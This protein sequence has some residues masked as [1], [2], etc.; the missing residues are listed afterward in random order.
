MTDPLARRA[1][2]G[3]QLGPDTL[4]FPGRGMC[5]VG[6]EPDS[7]AAE[8]E[9]LAG[10]VI[11]SLA[12]QS[13]SSLC[14]LGVALRCAGKQAQT[15]LVVERDGRPMTRDV[16]VQL[17]P[18]EHMAGSELLYGEVAARGARLRSILSVPSEQP[19]CAAVLLVQGIS[20]ESI[21]W[22]ASPDEP[23]ACLVQGWAQAGLMTMRVDKRGVGDSEGSP[24]ASADFVT[25]LSDVRAALAELLAHPARQ[26]AP[27]VLFGHSVGGMIAPMLAARAPVRGMMI[28]G[29]STANWLD[30]VSASTERQLRMQ[31]IDDD[32]LAKILATLRARVLQEGLNGRSA[33][34]H[35][36]L[37]SLDLREIW[38]Q[39][40]DTPTLVLCGQ[41]DWVLS[42]EEQVSIANIVGPSSVVDLS[43]LDHMLGF[44]ANQEHSL[45]NYGH[46]QYRRELLDK[47]LEWMR[48]LG[49]CCRA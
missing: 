32:E 44:H 5:I 8:A 46:G 37:Q 7:M 34:Y 43:G 35:R 33:A 6:V 2:L 45:S 24:C 23:M 49:V 15:Q 3:A 25:E 22:A 26:S 29:S 47:S 10:D 18:R 38:G 39:V 28:Y 19:P 48:E 36:Q 40:R 14:A 11:L 13:V 30:C 16:R 9:L 12:G 41:Y 20:C 4:A 21:D 42:R 1:Y 31:G 27:V 17:L